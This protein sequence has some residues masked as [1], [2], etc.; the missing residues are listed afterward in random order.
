MER[1]ISKQAPVAASSKLTSDGYG[2]D[3]YQVKLSRS[4]LGNPQG[5][6]QNL[7]SIT[8]LIN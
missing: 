2:K 4:C 8:L 3:D 1:T 7:K 6:T 5:E